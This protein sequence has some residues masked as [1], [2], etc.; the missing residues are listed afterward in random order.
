M[1]GVSFV[2]TR[3]SNEVT[4]VGSWMRAGHQKEGW[5][6]WLE[7]WNFQLYPCPMGRREGLEIELMEDVYMKKPS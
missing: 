7:A 6:P 1:T 4:L 3:R 2:P 5:L